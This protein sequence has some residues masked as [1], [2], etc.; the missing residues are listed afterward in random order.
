MCNTIILNENSESIQYLSKKDSNLKKL[1][2]L[3]GE[4]SYTLYADSYEFLVNTII[5]Q[6]LSNKVADIISNR[7]LN[8]CNGNI[9]PQTIIN[10]SYSQYFVL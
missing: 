9:E 6:M 4:I 5:G 3:I 1:F 7:L 10:L 2:N 8:L